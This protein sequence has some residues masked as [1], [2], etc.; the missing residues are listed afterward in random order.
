MSGRGRLAARGDRR[1]TRVAGALLDVVAPGGRTLVVGD[2]DGSVEAA[3]GGDRWS[4]MC[5][6]ERLGAAW[7]PDGPFDLVTLRIPKVRVALEMALHAAATRL[8]P[9]GRLVL[10]GANDEGIRS[11]PRK[12]EAV[13]EQVET[14]ATRRKCRVLE[15]SDPRPGAR[16]DLVDWRSEVPRPI[17]VGDPWV[18][19]PGLFARG[20]LDPGT[21]LLCQSLPEVPPDGKVLDFGCGVGVISAAVLALTPTARVDAVDAD[22]LA[23]EA[24]R[25]N[26]PGARPLLG[27]GW[28]GVSDTQYDCVLSNPPYHR[29]KGEDFAVLMAL[30]QGAADRLSPGGELR[31]VVPRQLTVRPHL[32]ERFA[33]VELVV[34]DPRYRVWAAR[35]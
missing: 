10:Y 26:V 6:G 19:W 34:D 21:A 7:P 15:A 29:G 8:A 2:A 4:R 16:G 12:L 30:L 23:L 17:G 5:V 24:V 9:G 18:T 11:A 3:L 22:A 32:E 25:H 20:G 1:E 35:T 14:V 28:G 33:Q 27:D 13:F 31:V